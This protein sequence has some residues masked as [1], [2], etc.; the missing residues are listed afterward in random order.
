MIKKEVRLDFIIAVLILVIFGVSFLLILRKQTPVDVIDYRSLTNS[1]AITT[2]VATT[3]VQEV[4]WQAITNQ[5]RDVR[6]TDCE[7][8]PYCDIHPKMF[9]LH[10]P[11]DTMKWR[12]YCDK[13]GFTTTEGNDSD[14]VKKQWDKRSKHEKEDRSGKTN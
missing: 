2:G 1:V 11:F 10:R 5:V 4:N 9:G 6:L 14:A 3:D 8:C 7:P 13:C 12:V